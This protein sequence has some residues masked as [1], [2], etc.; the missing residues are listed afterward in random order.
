MNPDEITNDVS[1]NLGETS[2]AT[3]EQWFDVRTIV[4]QV[5]EAMTRPKNLYAVG[6]T[7]LIPVLRATGRF[8]VRYP[9]LTAAFIGTAVI[10][11]FYFQ[12]DRRLEERILH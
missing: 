9:V 8:A 2:S 5:V 3:S 4:D 7:A 6:A 10:S 12:G 1:Q 11:F